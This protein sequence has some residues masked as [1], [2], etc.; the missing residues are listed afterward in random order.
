MVVIKHKDLV[1]RV[2]G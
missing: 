1:L 2:A